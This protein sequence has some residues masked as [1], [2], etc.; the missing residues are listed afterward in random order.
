[1]NLA[2]KEVE[3]Y[4]SPNGGHYGRTKHA[5]RSGIVEIGGSR[6]EAF[7]GVLSSGLYLVQPAGSRK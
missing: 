3:V 7:R 1:V 2:A 4:R 6:S 5:G